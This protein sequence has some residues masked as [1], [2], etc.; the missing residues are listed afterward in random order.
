VLE[1]SSTWQVADGGSTL[2]R[3]LERRR[4]CRF[5]AKFPLV[6]LYGFLLGS[7][8][9]YSEM[10][11]QSTSGP[12]DQFKSKPCV[13]SQSSSLLLMYRLEREVCRDEQ[14]TLSVST[15]HE[16]VFVPLGRFLMGNNS[17]YGECWPERGRPI[18]E[19]TIHKPQSTFLGL[20]LMVAPSSR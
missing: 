5:S 7:N 16:Y 12:S 13:N 19:C 8:G 2:R 10:L 1:V 14:R 17:A 20:E 4:P 18:S 3:R 6:S 9:A 15:K 11:A